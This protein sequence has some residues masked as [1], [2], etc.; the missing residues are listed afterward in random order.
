MYFE[1]FE[2]GQRFVTE[3]L[4]L[5][6][7]DI[8]AYAGKYDPIPLHVNED[9]ANNSSFNG[10]I[11]SGFH[12]LSTIWGQWIRLKKLDTEVIAGLGIDELKFTAPVRPG[13]ALVTAI[14]VIEK[15]PTSKGGKGIVTINISASNQNGEQVITAKVKS[16]MKSREC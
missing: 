15:I 5:T 2:I 4:I 16:L 6:K 14:E 3:P 1:D 12:T 11:A 13:D 8:M 9:F 10:V 7:E